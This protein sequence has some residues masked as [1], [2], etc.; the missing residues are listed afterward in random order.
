MRSFFGH[1]LI[2][3]VD[4]WLRRHPDCCPRCKRGRGKCVVESAVAR[5]LDLQVAIEADDRSEEV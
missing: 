5:L 1:T 3:A 4:D 2:S